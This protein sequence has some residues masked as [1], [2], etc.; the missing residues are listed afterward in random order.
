MYRLAL[1]CEAEA[2]FRVISRLADRVV[3]ENEKAHWLRDTLAHVRIWIGAR[4]SESFLPWTRIDQESIAVNA[5]RTLGLFN[6]EPGI[7]HA[8]ATRKALILFKSMINPPDAVLLVADADTEPDRRKGM[9]QARDVRPWPWGEATIVATP[10]REMETWEL[11]GFIAVDDDEKRLLDA[12]RT[13]LGF[14]PCID[15]H[16]LR[17][18]HGEDRDPKTVLDKLCLGNH[19]RR[20]DCAETDFEILKER[21]E[22][23]GLKAFLEEVETRLVPVF[24]K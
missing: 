2:D 15:A 3:S 21:G 8:A 11:A 9:V 23:S 24:T 1:V 10:D 13:S 14:D 18:T 7:V 4:D 22:A 17:N 5:P 19:D 16:R 20:G 6:G 12:Q